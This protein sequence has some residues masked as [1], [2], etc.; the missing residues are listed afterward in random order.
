MIGKIIVFSELDHDW[1]KKSSII[2]LVQIIF[3]KKENS[4]PKKIVDEVKKQQGSILI[5]GL[6]NVKKFDEK[7]SVNLDEYVINE[8]VFYTYS[9]SEDKILAEEGLRFFKNHIVKQII[10]NIEFNSY[11]YILN[12]DFEDFASKNLNFNFPVFL[13]FYSKAMY[14]YNNGKIISWNLESIRYAGGNVKNILTTFIY[15]NSQSVYLFSYANGF[16]YINDGTLNDIKTIS[17]LYYTRHNEELDEHGLVLSVD[18]IEYHKLIPY[19]SSII[20][21]R[22]RVNLQ[23]N[24]SIERFWRKDIITQWLSERQLHLSKK[25]INKNLSLQESTVTNYFTPQYSN[26][27]TLTGRINCIDSAFNPQRILK[28]SEERRSIVSRFKNGK[29]VTIDY[30]AFETRLSLFLCDDK[31]FI[32]KN[33]FTDFHT[34]TAKLLFNSLEV[35][36]K[37]RAL[38]K[39][40]NHI[41][42]YGGGDDKIR[43]RLKE[44]RLDTVF[45]DEIINKVKSYL[46]PLYSKATEVAEYYDEHHFIVN[47]FGTVIRPQKKWALYNNYIQA[48]AAEIVVEKLFEIKKFLFDNKLRSDLVF[49]VYDSFVFDFHPEELHFIEKLEEILN[50]FEHIEL[51]VKIEVSESFS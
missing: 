48:S 16:K 31:E 50:K 38:G 46:S 29:I 3:V 32:E 45:S 37:Q 18:D 5:V 44:E 15:N 35:D 26:K 23:E 27:R 22:I 4:I 2:P 34:E 36:E 49:Q 7:I 13:Y 11:D 21:E 9:L 8:N 17:N 33:K 39:T 30:N 40:I 51:P 47:I 6:S 41:I 14:S 43:Q 10:N 1:I 20:F 25:Y 19:F 42:A 12:G 24:T 28:G